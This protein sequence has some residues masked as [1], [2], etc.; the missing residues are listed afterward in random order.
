MLAVRGVGTDGHSMRPVRMPTPISHSCCVACTILLPAGVASGRLDACCRAYA[1]AV[2][3]GAEAVAEA[4]AEAEVQPGISSRVEKVMR[5]GT[6]VK[7]HQQDLT[8]ALG[9]ALLVPSLSPGPAVASLLERNAGALRDLLHLDIGYCTL[10]ADGVKAVLTALRGHVA[11]D[12]A[13]ALS[14]AA[15]LWSHWC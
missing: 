5:A 14:A 6:A 7:M 11:P 10:G 12:S 1:K 13:A 3:T 9:P 15:A 8:G 4:R 2:G